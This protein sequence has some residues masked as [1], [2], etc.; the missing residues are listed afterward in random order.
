MKYK[1]G[2]IVEGVITGIQAYG[3]FVKLDDNTT[4]LIHISELSDNFV[5][6]IE[7]YVCVNQR[8]IVK[9]IDVDKYSGQLRLSFKAI[10]QNLR[11]ETIRKKI[12][13]LPDDNIGFESIREMLPKWIKEKSI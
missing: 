5:R 11:K 3:A 12:Q 2:M 1:T 6:A 13:N 8:V 7:Q 10:H 9:V 4:G